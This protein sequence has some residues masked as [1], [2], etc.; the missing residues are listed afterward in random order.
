MK[1]TTE[2]QKEAIEFAKTY[3]EKTGSFPKAEHWV[4]KN[5]AFEIDR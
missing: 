2:Q 3:K 4:M 5:V 1:L